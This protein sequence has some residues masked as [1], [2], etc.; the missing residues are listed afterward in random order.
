M[1][2]ADDI[3]IS[4]GDSIVKAGEEPTVNNELDV[5]LCW[6]DENPAVAG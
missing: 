1:Q 5:L 4:R 2:L 3:D 6:M